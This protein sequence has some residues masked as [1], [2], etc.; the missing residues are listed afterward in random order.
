M[1]MKLTDF[2]E[3][4]VIKNGKIFDP[5]RKKWYVVQ[6]EE[7]VR[8]C[9]LLFFI[10]QLQWNPAYIGVEKSIIFAHQTKR[11]DIVLYNSKNKPQVL[12]E[13]K[14]PNVPLTQIVFE[15]AIRY[16]FAIGAPYLLL[17]NGQEVK[18][19]LVNSE[20]RSYQEMEE[21]TTLIYQ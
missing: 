8:Q 4:L 9:L 3:D 11:F 16:N 14:A 17:S 20:Q 7:L 21:W 5:I 1:N 15:Q 18:I 12:V 2:W 6:P 10:E 19:Y 13:C